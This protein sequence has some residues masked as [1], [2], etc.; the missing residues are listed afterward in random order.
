MSEEKE[1]DE[2]A[3][4]VP[5]ST[6]NHITLR[7]MFK[8]HKGMIWQ[9]AWSPDGTRLASG[10]RDK[11]IRIWDGHTDQLLYTLKGHT[12][13][14]YCVAWSPDGTRLVSG[15][16]DKTIRIWDGHS[17]LLLHTLAIHTNQ[18]Y[19][20]AWS[21]DGTHL[22]SGS[23]DNTV[24]IWDGYSG[25]LLHTLTDHT[26]S[27]YSVAWSPDGTLLASGS[28]D[29][30][31][32]IWD[33]HSARLLYTLEEHTNF[34]YSVAWSPD[35][36]HLASGSGDHTIY[37]WASDTWQPIKVLEG[38]TTIVDA[39]SFSSDGRFLASKSL[40]G[41][42]RI[43]NPSSWETV[44]LLEGVGTD[45]WAVF[46]VAF[47]PHDPILAT[48]S[49]DGADICIWDVNTDALLNALP[50]I[51]SIHYTS[52]K[53]ALVGDSGVGKSGPGYRIAEDRFEKTESTHGQQFWVVEKLV[54]TQRQG[55]QCEAVLWDFAGQPN[56]RPIHALF[57]DD[58][59]LA[60]V[61]FDPARA[62]TM[63]AVEYWLKQLSHKQHNTILVAARTDV[64][65]ITLSPAELETFCREHGING[66]F[67]V[68]SAKTNVGIDDLTELIRQQIDWNTK[69]TTVTTKTFKCIKDYVLELKAGAVTANIIVTSEQLRAQLEENNPDWEFSNTEMLEAVRHLQNH[70]Y[71]TILR[72][73]SYAQSILL[74]PDLLINLAA[75]FLL[76]AQANEKGLGSLEEA[77]VLHNAYRFNEVEALGE[78][79]RETLVN[80]A[81]EL[82][83]SHSLCFRES[84]D[85]RTFLIFPSLI[86]E[87]PPRLV[88]DTE[89]VEDITYVVTGEVEN[90]YAALVVLLGYS[91]TFQHMNQ[92][93][94]RA[95][96]ETVRNEICGFRSVDDDAG[97]LELVLYY[98][99]A[100]LVR[101][102]IVQ[103]ETLHQ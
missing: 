19:S 44:E 72:R 38:H 20:V 77:L 92:W 56:F 50:I 82:F 66:G 37:L 59:D 80:A 71:V 93:R 86:L 16:H 76:R 52:A 2:P 64:S 54:E 58:I 14:V 67:V 4:R 51:T 68:T 63:A 74:A 53:I 90:L 7:H 17:G 55:T 97:K 100:H 88:E 5:R 47:H 75:S 32:C 25:L 43:W 79:E 10:S 61:V 26:D 8:G 98:G 46:G 15:S 49:P 39:L 96:Y 73:S 12:D 34:V 40:N 62:D 35:G 85:N 1:I 31:V 102:S 78:E 99:Y 27:V 89:L 29:N 94:K 9:L 103:C 41:I 45:R 57:L 24:R 48:V 69:S 3:I 83:L 23:G 21:P 36:T 33:A 81:I 6:A 42:V 18:V 22:A 65:Q 91:P 101:D 11:T 87:R 70:G 84:I 13:Y 95:Q 28:Q 60:L 30:S